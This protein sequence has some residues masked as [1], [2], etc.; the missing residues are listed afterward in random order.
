MKKL[1]VIYLA[2]LASSFMFSC[3]P[4]K[5]L[6]ATFEADAL[7]A[8]PAKD[9]P[10]SPS[11]DVIEYHTGVEPQLKVQTSSIAG[12]KALHYTNVVIGEV[13]AHQRGIVF[14]GVGTALTKTTWITYTGQNTG[15]STKDV[16]IYVSDG[17]GHFMAAMRIRANG[18]V[19][20]TNDL[21]QGNYAVIGNV[22]TEVH[23]V[24]FTLS[25]ST[26]KYNVT[27]FKETG[28]AILAENKSMITE[29]ALS[30]NNPARPSI[31]FAHQE[32]A[33]PGHTYAIGSV[34]IT[35]KKPN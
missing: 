31:S 19:G 15:A 12:A 16:Y 10:G 17:Y 22:G 14:K 35:R 27:I 6:V 18:E 21:A 24:I 11:G 5:I 3:Q 1:F 32:A 7:N 8:P 33:S 30:F 13:P 28:P 9:L 23:T 2:V 26:L 20:L 4:S 25:P 29:D 34:S